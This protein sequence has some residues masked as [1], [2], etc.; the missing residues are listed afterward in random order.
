VR[1]TFNNQEQYDVNYHRRTSKL[2]ELALSNYSSC[3]H[4]TLTSD[5]QF[6]EPVSPRVSVVS[7]QFRILYRRVIYI[8]NSG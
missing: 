7:W 5:Y 6:H 4:E 2:F 1:L 8:T 3:R